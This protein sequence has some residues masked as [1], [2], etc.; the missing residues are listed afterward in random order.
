MRGQV[1]TIK[2]TAL[3]SARILR[4]VLETWGQHKLQWK[5]SAN[6]DVKNSHRVLIIIRNWRMSQDYSI[7]I[8]Q[9]TEEIPGD[10]VWF[11]FFV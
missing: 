4:R 11:G 6:A 7:K 10:L 1:E 3:R 8:I 9:N 2:T 5:L